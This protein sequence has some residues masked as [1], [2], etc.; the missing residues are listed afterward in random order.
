MAD[1]Y[2]DNP[3]SLPPTLVSPILNV[4]AFGGDA[5]LY[6]RY[7]AAMKAAEAKPEE[8]YRFF[9]ALPTFTAPELRA[10]TLKFAMSAEARSQDAPQLIA[11]L[12]GSESSQDETWNFITS[13]WPAIMTKFGAF[14]GLPAIVNGLSGYCSAEKSDEI[15]KFFAAHP[16]PETARSLQLTLER[17][18]SC[19]AL[20]ARQAAAF[21][22]WLAAHQ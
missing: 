7:F 11:Q 12:L 6:D 1:K 20:K 10:R 14:Q 15:K 19:V 21:T 8:Y 16:V 2:L 18:D 4:A 5:R 13:N 3:S 17:I 9:G 22:A